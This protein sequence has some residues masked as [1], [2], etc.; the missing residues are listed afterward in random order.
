MR[1]F[2]THVIGKVLKMFGLEEVRSNKHAVFKRHLQVDGH[3]ISFMVV[4]PLGH[5]DVSGE[6]AKQMCRELGI[7]SLDNLN[8]LTQ[9]SFPLCRACHDLLLAEGR[10]R[11]HESK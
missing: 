2:N 1:K 8:M 11:V 5:Q 6:V 10:R 3:N 9:C 7:G 4:M